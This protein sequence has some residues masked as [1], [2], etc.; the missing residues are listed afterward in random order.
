MRLSPSSRRSSQ[1]DLNWALPRLSVSF[2]DEFIVL[3]AL[4]KYDH[5]QGVLLSILMNDCY[6][7]VKN[8]DVFNQILVDL[9]N[10]EH[11]IRS[12]HIPNTNDIMIHF[13]TSIE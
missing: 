4:Q 13:N 9:E 2:A 3:T 8:D 11:L 5:D 10:Y 7:E 6:C 12:A 1:G